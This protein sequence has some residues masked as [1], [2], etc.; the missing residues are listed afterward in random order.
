VG[1]L[2]D[3]A[4]EDRYEARLSSQGAGDSAAFGYMEDGAGQDAYNR[5]QARLLGGLLGSGQQ[6][7]AGFLLERGGDDVY[8][9][10][11]AS[12]GAGQSNGLGVFVDLGG[13]DDHTATNE[14]TW[15]YGLLGPEVVELDDPRRG[16]ATVGIFLDAGEAQDRYTRPDL[17]EPSP[18]QP[19]NDRAWLGPAS[20]G[21]Q[22]AGLDGVGLTGLE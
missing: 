13:L 6:Q 11:R 20:D 1:F 18:T 4:G 14:S 2:L 19:G 5:D 8:R 3:R 9:A 10:P 17:G 7:G 22:G 12:A 15:G 16:I 21:T